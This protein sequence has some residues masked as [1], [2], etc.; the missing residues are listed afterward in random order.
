MKGF[1]FL[2]C[3][4][5]SGVAFFTLP[6]SC[7]KQLFNPPKWVLGTEG[8]RVIPVTCNFSECLHISSPSGFAV[9]LQG[10]LFT[11]LYTNKIML[12]ICYMCTYTP[13]N[14]AG[15]NEYT[16]NFLERVNLQW[17]SLTLFSL[18]VHLNTDFYEL[19][20]RHVKFRCPFWL[21]E[22]VS[23]GRSQNSDSAV[24]L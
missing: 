5:D 3:Q 17:V 11:A 24:N 12:H 18:P 1:I 22:N 9:L 19:F 14:K 2:L 7:A 16:Q 8:D 10:V 15:V 20:K 21:K 13:G 23:D 4:H 6:K